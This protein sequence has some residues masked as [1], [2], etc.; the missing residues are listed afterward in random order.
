MYLFLLFLAYMKL[1]SFPHPPIRKANGP[2]EI[3]DT[4]RLF[5]LEYKVENGNP[6]LNIPSKPLDFQHM[7]TCIDKSLNLFIKLLRTL[8]NEIINELRELHSHMND[9]INLAREYDS[10]NIIQEAKNKKIL[11]ER[12]IINKL[13]EE[14]N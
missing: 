8:D 5:G 12:E 6:H 4:F 13:K 9:E 14:I 7:K 3:P 11:A 10:E 1:P 2:P